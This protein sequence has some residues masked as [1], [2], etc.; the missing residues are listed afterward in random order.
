VI[1]TSPRELLALAE[2][3]AREA[4]ALLLRLRA[5]ERTGVGTKSSATDMVSDADRASERLIVERLRAVRPHDA[6][7]GEEGGASAG[8]SG[9]RWVIDPLDG[10][11]NYLYGLSHFAVSIAAERDGEAVAGVVYDP[12]HDEMFAASLGGGAD[13]NGRPIAVSG[14]ADLATALVAT[15][16]GYEAAVRA[17]QGRVIARVLPLVRDFR[18]HGAAALDLCNVA[19]G[20][21]D[22]YFERGLQVWDMA[23]GA[24]I[25]REAGGLTSAI[26]GGSAVPGS[27]VAATPALLE[28]LRQVV[29]EAEEAGA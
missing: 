13:L 4:G 26:E 7:L 11:T 12:V 1:D 9:V 18:R 8:T 24:L 25:V 23:A 14:L 10:T 21:V 29:A 20:R 2:A 17:Q 3:T 5:T 22:A 15:G 19:C 6:I 28:P 27:M 16:F